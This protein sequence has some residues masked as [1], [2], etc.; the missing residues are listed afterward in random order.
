MSL[1]ETVA[2]A[3]R[4]FSFLFINSYGI[5]L[6][7]IKSKVV[8]NVKETKKPKTKQRDASYDIAGSRRRNA[9]VLISTIDRYLQLRNYD[10]KKAAKEMF[11]PSLEVL[12]A[13][14]LEVPAAISAPTTSTEDKQRVI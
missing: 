8:V 3:A 13:T 6:S 5:R 9:A 10:M 4:N 2:I 14:I 7:S 11:A 12:E 1:K